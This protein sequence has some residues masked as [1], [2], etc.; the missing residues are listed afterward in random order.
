MTPKE[1]LIPRYRLYEDYPNCPFKVGHVLI[2]QDL[3]TTNNPY[4]EVGKFGLPNQPSLYNPENYPANFVKLGWWEMRAI[5][6]W[7]NYLRDME[8]K[9]FQ[10]SIEIEP[11]LHILIL[12][13]NG[14]SINR[15][16]HYLTP[17]SE[18]EYLQ[19][20]EKY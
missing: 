5:S 9:V 16:F 2:Q 17:A 4:Y 20:K 15:N 10:V 8:G 18:Q 7:P 13:V 11:R 19:Y 12:D 14:K 3:G 6:D 1:L